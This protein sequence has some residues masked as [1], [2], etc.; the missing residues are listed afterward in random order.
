MR[1]RTTSGSPSFSEARPPLCTKAKTSLSSSASR[2][3]RPPVICWITSWRGNG[4]GGVRE[5]G[6][7]KK[8]REKVKEKGKK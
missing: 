7:N 5:R 4:G 3:F 6:K 1:G 8:K 2:F